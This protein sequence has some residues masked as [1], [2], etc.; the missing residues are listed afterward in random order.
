MN[1]VCEREG[2]TERVYMARTGYKFES[3][4][5]YIS[6]FACDQAKPSQANGWVLTGDKVFLRR[7]RKRKKVEERMKTTFHHSHCSHNGS[8]DDFSALYKTYC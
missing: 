6:L 2:E 5:S 7:Q 4:T 1:H 3:H 8:H